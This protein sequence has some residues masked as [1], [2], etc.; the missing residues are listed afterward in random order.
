MADKAMANRKRKKKPQTTIYKAI[1]R[2][3]DIEQH[4]SY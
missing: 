1:N 3:L 4:E 2:K